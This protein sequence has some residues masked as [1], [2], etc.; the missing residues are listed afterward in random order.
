MGKTRNLEDVR[1]ELDAIAKSYDEW[2]KKNRYFYESIEGFLKKRVASGARVLEIGCRTG[3]YLAA[4]EPSYGVGLDISPEM[5]KIAR[6]KYPRYKFEYSTLGSYDS[7]EKFDYILLVNVLGYVNDVTS[8]LENVSRFCHPTTKIII[9]TINPWW[10]FILTM[11]EK[12]QAKMPSAPHNYLD[13]SCLFKIIE[14]L[15]FSRISSG[16]MLL[17][18]KRIPVLSFLLNTIGTRTI[19]LNKLSFVQYTI[20]R[21]LSGSNTDLGYGCSVV[22]PCYNEEGN[23]AS[24]VKRV[25]RMGRETEIIVV[26]DGSKDGTAAIARG[27]VNEMDGVKLVS[28]SPNRGKGYAVKQGFDAAENEV[29]MILDAD[30][31]VPPEEL[32]RF[33]R[34]LNKGLCSFVNGTRMVYPMQDRAMKK[35]NLLGNKFFS[36]V[37][38]F[39]T[40]QQLTDTLCGTKALYKKDYKRIKMGVDKWGDFDLLFGAAKNGDKIL[41]VPV[42]YK[43]RKAGVSKMKTL[44][45]G[46]HLTKVCIRGFKE[47]IL[48]L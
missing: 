43:S 44:S 24:A 5:V 9:T 23:I 39:L 4:V 40:G 10:D 7:S 41:E 11:S 3:D 20:L 45:H 14:S 6:G 21:P 37:M 13:R 46:I 31:S 36:G 33:F 16:Y 19:G 26:D 1:H 28:Y 35:L 12:L 27:L 8:L 29:I 38:T 2:R 47:L 17:C 18:P 22:I 48:G 30:M 15:D 32:P 42:H 25:P 34:L